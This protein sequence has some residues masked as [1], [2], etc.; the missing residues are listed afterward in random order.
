MSQPK[1]ADKGKYIRHIIVISVLLVTSLDFVI[2]QEMTYHWSLVNVVGLGLFL[3]GVSIRIVALRTLG[4]Y[5]LP[6]LKTMQNHK[7]IK[8]GVYKH[9]RHPCYL[10][11]ILFSLG[12][13]LIF[14][15]LY[16]FSLILILIP[17]Y[18]YRIKIEESILLE[19]FGDEY[20]EYMKKTRKI[21]PFIY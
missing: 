3:I 2:I 14:S 20:Q 6:D 10:G 16:G 12:I 21:I 8:H 13:P 9:V 4:K 17:C 18:L 1:R 11:S 5:F 15:S 7:L 19:E